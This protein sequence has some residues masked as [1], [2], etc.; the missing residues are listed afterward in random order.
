MKILIVHNHYQQPGGEDVVARAEKELLNARGHQVVEYVRHNNEIAGYGRWR[1]ATLAPRTVWAWDSHREVKALLRRERP[2]IAHF[3]NTFPLI[4]P[5]AYYACR[6]AGVPVVQSLH[7]ARLVCPVATFQRN[8][9][10]CQDCLGRKFAWPAVLHA[11]YRGSRTGSSVVAATLAIH[12]QLGTWNKLVDCFIVATD[13]YRRKFVEAGLPAEKIVVKP[14]FVEDY[15]VQRSAGTYALFVGRLAP[16]KGVDTLLGAWRRL[17]HIPLRVR[18]EGPLEGNVQRLA[19]ESG[20]AVQLLPRL[21]KGELV[22]LM[23]GARFLVWPS[24]GYY[25]TFG[26]VAAEAFSCGIPVIASRVGVA[27]EIV[28]DG[29]TGLHFTPADPQDLAAKA[30]WAWTHPSEMEAMGRAARAEY[31]SKYTA[32]RNHPMLTEIYRRVLGAKGRGLGTGAGADDER[33]AASCSS[34]H[35]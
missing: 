10:V 29:R 19:E 20:G 7:N 35:I 31:E 27:E 25:E 15:G 33:P 9:R 28:A 17:S 14:H 4:S 5:A 23:Q 13:F 8:H 34:V 11:C 2:D 26:Y 12:W 32:E 1:R 22:R 3:H 18:G 24:E 6:R 16:E 21:A 30:E